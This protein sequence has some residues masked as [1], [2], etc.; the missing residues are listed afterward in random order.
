MLLSSDRIICDGKG[1][2]ANFNSIEVSDM[3]KVQACFHQ[4]SIIT[5]KPLSYGVRD[6]HTSTER[7]YHAR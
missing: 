2:V 6:E 4:W 1:E 3:Y 7:K 5:I